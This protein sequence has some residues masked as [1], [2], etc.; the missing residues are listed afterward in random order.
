[1]SET[2]KPGS[3]EI[4]IDTDIINE[5][6]NNLIEDTLKICSDYKVHKS[7]GEEFLAKLN[8]NTLEIRKRLEDEFS[9]VIIGNFKRG[10]S[11]F[12]NALLKQ[13]IAP[14][15]VTPET[16]AI[17]K[18]S[19]GE[20]ISTQ[21]ILED[22]RHVSLEKDELYRDELEEI[23]KTLPS[24]IDHIEMAVPIEGI[25]GIC[26]VDTPGLGDLLKQ[27]D[28]QIN[29]YLV[30]ADSVIYV[31][32]ALSPFSEEEQTF[33]R[34]CLVPQEFQ[35]LCIA[36]NFMDNVDSTKDYNRL[37]DNI[38]ARI[39]NI[40]PDANVFGISALDE[41]CRIK[42]VKRPNPELK[43]TL[44]Q[45]FDDLREH[46]DAN[47]FT[48]HELLKLQRVTSI[49]NM[50]INDLENHIF[51]IRSSMEFSAIEL[52]DIITKYQDED[53]EISHKLEKQKDT[54]E[55]EIQEMYL[56]ACTW[57]DEFFS[58]IQAETVS[59][60]KNCTLEGVIKNFHFFMVDTLRS[61]MTE[62]I[63][64]HIKKVITGVKS[65]VNQMD[66]DI[67][68]NIT[69][70]NINSVSKATFVDVSWTDLDNATGALTVASSFIPGFSLLASIGQ[71]IL[72]VGK[73]SME[74]KQ[75]KSYVETFE[76]RLPEIKENIYSELKASY[77]QIA[78]YAKEQLETGYKDTLEE[79]LQAIK[80]SKVIAEAG[81]KSKLEIREGLERAEFFMNSVHKRIDELE[82]KIVIQ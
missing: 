65:L 47:I 64:Y 44:A 17:N 8:K 27:F 48:Q 58:R 4:W 13:E 6:L 81:E 7:I 45:A 35:K 12:I 25:R 72:G 1:M 52:S 10:K 78:K 22:K 16:V 21:V 54:L 68:Y 38:K 30:H 20:N 36:V 41:I 32:S 79:S 69:Q 53:S 80:Q 3:R 73:G 60:L 29:N 46:L 63:N 24:P 23:K 67:K 61:A 76:A 62:C 15:N 49:L 11:S 5:E 28:E 18:I 74:G 33:L 40:V 57:I 34:C 51:L 37:L 2:I 75:L 31:I 39:D 14:T 55:L 42:N 70:G 19:Y 56:E 26:I 82:K 71:V 9:I 50:A 77:N 59:S 66:Q 43:D